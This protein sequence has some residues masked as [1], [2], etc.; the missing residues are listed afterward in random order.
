MAKEEK[1]SPKWKNKI[2]FWKDI[3]YA[4]LADVP[5]IPEQEDFTGRYEK[6]AYE[7]ESENVLKVYRELR[8]SL[9]KKLLRRLD[10][11]HTC[12]SHEVFNFCL[13]STIP[14]NPIRSKVTLLAP[15]VHANTLISAKLFMPPYYGAGSIYYPKKPNI[16]MEKFGMCPDIFA[17][18]LKHFEK[19]DVKRVPMG[20]D[21]NETSPLVPSKA[22]I[23]K[24]CKDTLRDG[25]TFLLHKNYIE[26]HLPKTKMRF[27]LPIKKEEKITNCFSNTFSRTKSTDLVIDE[28]HVSQI[29]SFEKLLVEK[30][31]SRTY[32]LYTVI[33][34]L[35]EEKQQLGIFS[36]LWFLNFIFFFLFLVTLCLQILT[37]IT[38]HHE[39][40][41]NAKIKYAIAILSMAFFQITLITIW[42]S[43]I[44]IEMKALLKKGNHIVGNAGK[45]SKVRLV[46][47]IVYDLVYSRNNMVIVAII[48]LIA[49]TVFVSLNIAKQKSILPIIAALIIIILAGSFSKDKKAIPWVTIVCLLSY[50][51]LAMCALNTHAVDNLLSI[52]SIDVLHMTSDISNGLTK[53]L[54]QETLSVFLHWLDISVFFNFVMAAYL[55]FSLFYLIM[56]FIKPISWILSLTEIELTY[57]FISLLVPFSSVIGINSKMLRLLTESELSLVLMVCFIGYNFITACAFQMIGISIKCFVINT[58]VTV[59]VGLAFSKIIFP[60][61]KDSR[62]QKRGLFTRHPPE[63]SDTKLLSSIFVRGLA[64]GYQMLGLYL[65]VYVSLSYIL[66]FLTYAVNILTNA[67][68]TNFI[69]RLVQ[70]IWPVF[71]I[72]GLEVESEAKEVANLFLNRLIINNL[73]GA[74]LTGRHLA[75]TWLTECKELKSMYFYGIDKN[76]GSI[77]FD[78]LG[79]ERRMSHRALYIAQPFALLSGNLFSKILTIILIASVRCAKFEKLIK[80]ATKAFLAS[81]LASLYSGIII[82]NVVTDEDRFVCTAELISDQQSFCNA[83]VALMHSLIKKH[84]NHTLRLWREE[85]FSETICFNLFPPDYF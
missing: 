27:E 23:Y 28:E 64:T 83:F 56:F 66:D 76:D 12:N 29:K 58:A 81:L 35:R 10:S 26:D 74:R 36:R 16:F 8:P 13:D 77:L 3:V 39:D 43:G 68:Q 50:A 65:I 67:S 9:E 72:C 45:C 31:L 19:L 82:G 57:A 42:V 79:S 18:E 15:P 47:S 4:F 11:T 33:R 49:V 69:R 25:F 70:I 53:L 21:M 51:Y 54:R 61:T 32:Y 5:Y 75:L 52:L 55:Y 73:Q 20:D 1:E 40:R 37:G 30:F 84:H 17:T 62:T 71:Y 34:Y 78:F 2:E 85:L 22:Y 48:L 7:R 6:G 38:L 46:V 24:F 14:E 63:V 80:I 59:P 60:E 41:P 44:S